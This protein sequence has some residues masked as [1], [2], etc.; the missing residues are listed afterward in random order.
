MLCSGLENVGTMDHQWNGDVGNELRDCGMTHA[1]A[2][3]H[4][5]PD[6]KILE[7]RQD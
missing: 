3:A 4:L 7:G 6:I 2:E 1:L 5:F